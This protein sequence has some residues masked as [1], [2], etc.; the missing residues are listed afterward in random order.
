VRHLLLLLLLLLSGLCPGSWPTSHVVVLPLL[1]MV[2][3]GSHWLLQL[4]VTA[5]YTCR[6]TT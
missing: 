2:D 6:Q 3:N 1:A 4:T 5:H